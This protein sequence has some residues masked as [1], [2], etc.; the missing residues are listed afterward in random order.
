MKMALMSLATLLVGGCLSGCSAEHWAGK[1]TMR[2]ELKFNP[3]TKTFYFVDTKDND[4]E[5]EDLEMDAE[6]KRLTLARLKIVNNSSTA[7]AAEVDRILAVAEAQKTQV[8][9]VSALTDGIGNVVK[10]LVPLVSSLQGV[11]AALN[12]D[13]PSTIEQ[14]TEALEA[15]E[16]LQQVKEI[17]PGATTDE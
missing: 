11:I 17:T 7:I 13:D 1:T 9:Y 8:E 14:L 16:A 5:M 10:E 2:T 12:P 3:V 15:L 4:I 6:S